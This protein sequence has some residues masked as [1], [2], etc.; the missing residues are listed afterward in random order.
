[1]LAQARAGQVARAPST[2]SARRPK[3]STVG[4][5]CLDWRGRAPAG[6]A[7]QGVTLGLVAQAG[8]MGLGQ[9]I[10]DGG[11]HDGLLGVAWCGRCP[12]DAAT[13]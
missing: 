7:G 4:S 5:G 2:A 13:A 12:E 11:V 3:D 8:Q 1:M 6:G 9:L 10:A